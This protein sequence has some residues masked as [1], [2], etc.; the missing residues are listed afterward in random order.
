MATECNL[1]L[2]DELIKVFTP[3]FHSSREFINFIYN[4]HSL[5]APRPPRRPGRHR[6]SGEVRGEVNRKCFHGRRFPISLIVPI[7]KSSHSHLWLLMRKIRWRR[8]S[9]PGEWSWW[10]APWA[11]AGAGWGGLPWWP[12]HSAS[13]HGCNQNRVNILISPVKFLCE[14]FC[15]ISRYISLFVLLEITL[16]VRI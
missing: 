11:G 5:A 7:F 12:Q 2:R 8:R 6:S 10:P 1:A 4:D 3:D 16:S 14:Y 15:Y 9:A 13:R